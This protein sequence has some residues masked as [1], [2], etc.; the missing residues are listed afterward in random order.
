MFNVD[1]QRTL[2]QK[3]DALKWEIHELLNANLGVLKLKLHCNSTC[4]HWNTLTEVTGD[5]TGTM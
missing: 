3:A 1:L 4:Y 2:K 5:N